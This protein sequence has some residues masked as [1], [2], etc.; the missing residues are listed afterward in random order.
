MLVQSENVRGTDGSGPLRVTLGIE[1]EFRVDV[2]D[3][4]Q[5]LRREFGD[6]FS[7]FPKALYVSYHTTAGYLDQRFS[8]RLNHDGRDVQDYLSVFHELFPPDAGYSHDELH[9]REELSEAQ[10]ATEPRNADSHLTFMG[11]GLKNCATYEGRG[12]EPVWFVELDGVHDAGRRQRKTTVVGFHREEE[13]ARLRM[14]IPASDHGLD[15]L[16]L[17][18]PDLGFLRQLQELPPKYGVA[19]G[20]IDVSLPPEE[21]HA[22]LTVNEYETL[23]MRHDLREVLE[24]P[25][26]FMAEKG[27]SALR[28]PRAIPAKTLNYAQFDA[29][30]LLNKVMDKVGV[31]QSVVE[32]LVNRALALPVSHFLRMKR[33][34][35]LPV[36]DEESTGTGQI[37]SGTYQSPIL[38][39]WRRP[40]RATRVVDVRVVRFI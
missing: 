17:R 4:N 20:R 19:A 40:E 11:A 15:A 28:D 29:V 2:I 7:R 25:L 31:R 10:K 39:Q 27:K 38:V 24:N 8:A 5:R 26:R 9:L 12:G 37:V 18:N 1:P 34:L 30:Q 3:V 33:S 22:G 23:L 36:L 14:E 13:V 6:G 16:D 35:S 32:R 21:R